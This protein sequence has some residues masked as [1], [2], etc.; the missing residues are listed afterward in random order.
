[1]IK[2]TMQFIYNYFRKINECK[3]GSWYTCDQSPFKDKKDIIIL[4][5][6]YKKTRK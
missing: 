4:P 1:M 3:Y 5:A 6:S 2:K